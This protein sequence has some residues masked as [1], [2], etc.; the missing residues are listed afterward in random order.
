MMLIYCRRE[1]CRQGTHRGRYCDYFDGTNPNGRKKT[2]GNERGR[3]NVNKEGGDR[4]FLFLLCHSGLAA[5]QSDPRFQAKQQAG[6]L[7]NRSSPT[8]PSNRQ[9]KGWRKKESHGIVL[10][11]RNISST[12]NY[13][14]HNFID[15]RLPSITSAAVPPLCC[16]LGLFVVYLFLSKGEKEGCKNFQ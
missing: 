5:C 13:Y 11:S 10:V 12:I 4:D 2:R 15:C 7:L 1:T 16:G 8:I 14:N 6:P 9:R 3:E